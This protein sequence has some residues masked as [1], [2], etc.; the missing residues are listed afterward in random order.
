MQIT[1]QAFP[2]VLLIG[3][4]VFGDRRGHFLEVSRRSATRR[5]ASP[6]PSSRTTFPFPSGGGAGPALYRL[7]LPPGKAHHPLHRGDLGRGGGCAP[8]VAHLREAPVGHLDRRS[9]PPA[10]CPT[11]FAHGLPRPTAGPRCCTSA[12]FLPPRG[13]AR[14]YL[15]RPGLRDTL[16][17]GQPRCLGAG[18]ETAPPQGPGPRSRTPGV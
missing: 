18:P 13:R 10:L 6:A 3:P 11:R 9:L 12:P 5:A 15:E 2:E 17:G 14:H 7:A 16:A 1:P 8:G 4:R